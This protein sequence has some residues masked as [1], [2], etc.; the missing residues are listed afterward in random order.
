[1][2]QTAKETVDVTSLIKGILNGYPGSSAI[3]REYLQNSDDAKANLQTFLLDETSYP[4]TSLVDPVL[5]DSQGSA[6]IAM[7][8]QVLSDR[9]WTALRKIHASSKITDE[10]QTG[11]NGLGF[12]ASY[13]LTEN[14][15]ILSGRTLMILDPH[16]EFGAFP[17]GIAIDIINEGRD[18][19][20]QLA[21]F[22]P[23]VKDPF[24][25][26]QG[27]IFRLPLR[28]KT[29]AIRSRI[30]N[31]ATAVS[32]IK[33]LLESFGQNELEE[34]ILF[35]KNISTIEI[36]HISSSGKEYSIGRATIDQ[37]NDSTGVLFTRQVNCEAPIGN[38]RSRT[39]RF[40]TCKFDKSTAAHVMSE[41]LGYNIGDE[42]NKEK[43]V[44]NVELAM[45]LGGPSIQGRLFTL[46]PLPIKTGFPLHFNAVFALTP[47][48]Q[49]LKNVEEAGLPESRER[50]LVEWNRAIFENFGPTAW[51][52]ILSDITIPSDFWTAW[53]PEEHDKNSYWAQLIPSIFKFAITAKLPIFPLVSSDGTSSFTTLDDDS[54]LLAPSDPKVSLALLVRLGLMV[55]QPP[56][57][58]FSILTSGTVQASASVL[59]PAAVHQVLRLKYLNGTN[60]SVSQVDVAEAIK[61]LVFSTTTPT[62]D[63]IFELPWL[64]HEDR[65]PATLARRS[66]RPCHIVPTTADEASILFSSCNNMLS[67]ASMSPELQI[68]LA[69]QASLATSIRTTD[70]ILLTPDHVINYLQ[71]KFRGFNSSEAEVAAGSTVIDWLVCFWKWTMG[72]NEKATLFRRS[73]VFHNLHLLP[74]KHQTIRKISSKIMVFKYVDE[75]VVAAWAQLGIHSLH[76]ELSQN[77]P[78]VQM[79]VVDGFAITPQNPSYIG[80]LANDFVV[81]NLIELRAEA[82]TTIHQSLYQAQL[83][84]QAKLSPSQKEKF[85]RLPIFHIR[86]QYG[87]DSMLASVFGDRRIL[88]K[89]D[90]DVPLPLFLGRQPIYVDVSKPG[91]QKLIDMV[92]STSVYNELD[93]LQL[94]IDNWEAQSSYLKEKFI[95]RIVDNLPKMKLPFLKPPCDLLDPSSPLSQLYTG[96]KENGNYLKMMRAY[97]FFKYISDASQSNPTFK[98]EKAQALVKILNDNWKDAY[99]PIVVKSRTKTWLPYIASEP[100]YEGLNQH[101]HLYDLVFQ[102]LT[103]APLKSSGLSTDSLR[104][105]ARIR[106]LIT[107]FGQLHAQ[108]MLS[109]EFLNIAWVPVSS[110]RD[111]DVMKPTKYALLSETKLQ[112]PFTQVSWR[113]ISKDSINF[114][115]AM[116]CTS[117]PSLDTLYEELRRLLDSPVPNI[118]ISIIVLEEITQRTDYDRAA[119]LVPSA[120]GHIRTLESVYYQDTPQWLSLST[121]LLKF[122]LHRKISMGLAEQL[123]VPLLSSVLLEQGVDEGDDSDE[124]QMAEDLR[125]RIGGFLRENDV[126]YAVNEFL[127]NADDAK[128]TKFSILLDNRRDFFGT[129]VISPAFETLQSSSYIIFYNDAVLS[130]HDFLGLKKVGRGGKTDEI[131]THGRHGLGALAFYY[132]TDTPFVISGEYVM[133]LDPTSRCLPLRYGQRRT[134]LQRKIPN[135]IEMYPDQL[136]RFENLFGFSSSLLTRSSQTMF[137]LPLKATIPRKSCD[138]S[139]CRRLIQESYKELAQNAF[140]FTTHLEEISAEE[141][142]TTFLSAVN[143]WSMSST[144]SERRPLGDRYTRHKVSLNIEVREKIPVLQEWIVS[145]CHADI[146]KEHATTAANLKL[147]PKSNM[148]VQ[149]ALK[150]LNGPD[151]EDSVSY[152]FSTLRL[153]KRNLLPFHLHARFAISSNR[154]N[155]IFSP[156]Y[157]SNYA[158]D[159]K[160]AFNAQFSSSFRQVKF[161]SSGPPMT[162]GYV[163]KKPYFPVTSQ[164]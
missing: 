159:P 126:L 68:Y 113:D 87:Q 131:D 94:A 11:K 44:A 130:K 54:I 19:Q 21:P 140:F 72:W 77:E 69:H 162:S 55:V 65:S 79:L 121:P 85:S 108:G 63:N 149:I 99:G 134:S 127:A 128:A 103:L 145:T 109:D 49:S 42:L 146:P 18:Y 56:A 132:F 47:D 137:C 164:P 153:P 58:I 155:L 26:Y 96:E 7:N 84:I 147:P 95:Q 139:E 22:I 107:H 154:Q 12:R 57:H 13:H 29:Q 27:T 156:G 117:R 10:S 129:R 46:L 45:P 16:N 39:W 135:I 105:K 125:D 53:P 15:Q 157:N 28:T 9:D 75:A 111:P 23:I 31:E 4:T 81:A 8:D 14:P 64:F 38:L 51:V 41:R 33:Q 136:R 83:A 101:P 114:L 102:V 144:R 143:Y 148:T 106:T 100:L 151:N 73:G 20:D 123:M 67:W 120:D 35:L 92:E 89:V 110:S 150:P 133:I 115:R 80:F 158:D 43:L 48:R 119:V 163:S 88:V 90:T 86:Q 142:S 161:V 2:P 32:E 17:G 36:R 138:S 116:G 59:S 152:L 98:F 60:T 5:Q 50:R 34:A 52:N 97:D 24:I 37:R 122:P 82:R 160:T 74:T 6:L 1:M 66:S 78:L 76:S 40:S 93:L 61:Y 112:P 25:F 62:I 118:D 104:R 30:K 70:V 124:E 141:R 3:L 91:T 71:E